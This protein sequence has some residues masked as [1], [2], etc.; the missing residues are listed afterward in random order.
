VTA[1][2]IFAWYLPRYIPSQYQNFS[3]LAFIL[4]ELLVAIIILYIRKRI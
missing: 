2:S 4:M 3:Y 1:A